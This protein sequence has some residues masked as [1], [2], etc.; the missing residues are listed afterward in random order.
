[1]N[2]QTQNSWMILLSY[3]AFLVRF[4]LIVF[5]NVLYMKKIIAYTGKT[6]K[7]C[8]ILQKKYAIFLRYME[9]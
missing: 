4:T 7:V 2:V 9:Q 8:M 6:I 1:M 3:H 5:N